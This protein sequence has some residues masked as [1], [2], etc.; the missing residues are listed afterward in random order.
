MVDDVGVEVEVNWMN[1]LAL[2]H[3]SEQKTGDR[4][5]NNF[6]KWPH[7]NDGPFLAGAET[8]RNQKSAGGPP[9]VSIRR[10]RSQR[11]ITRTQF[12][13]NDDVDDDERTLLSKVTMC[14]N[15]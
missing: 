9:K 13:Q 15:E 8:S 2:G 1:G 11:A 6:Q 3:T 12:R 4:A 7:S 14:A 10:G 5:V